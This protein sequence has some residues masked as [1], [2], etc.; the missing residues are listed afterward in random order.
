MGTYLDDDLSEIFTEFT[1]RKTPLY[2]SIILSLIGGFLLSTNFSLILFNLGI[3]IFSSILIIMQIYRFIENKKIIFKQLI[4]GLI[5]LMFLYIPL[6]LPNQLS[7][8]IDNIDAG[9]GKGFLLSLFLVLIGL[10]GVYINLSNLDKQ[11]KKAKQASAYLYLSFAILTVL[12]V[13]FLIIGFIVYNGAGA[14]TWEFIT[15]DIQNMGASGG[16]FP[17]IIGT[18]L[19]GLG[20][21]LISVPLGVGTAIFL[22]EYA[23][24]QSKL[25]RVI[26]TSIN[27]LNAT[28]SIVHGLFGLALFVPLFGV[29]LLTGSLVLGFLTLPI[30]IRSTEEALESVPKDIRDASF[31]MGATRWQ[32]IRNAV[33]PPALPGIVTGAVL[34]LGR[35]FGETAPI[36]FTAVIFSGGGIPTSV[37]DSVNALSYHLLEL[38]RLIGYKDVTQKAWGTALLLL[39]IV[40]AMNFLGIRIRKKYRT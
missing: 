26:R 25:V 1:L 32:T 14:I 8:P 12:F 9:I 40:L 13:L 30:I 6:I 31:A 15:Q 11:N 20:T 34:G 24:S 2:F 36:M 22:K 3:L 29:S 16:V 27:V 35:A 19:L 21:A 17:A 23:G 7:I 38:T 39:L 5:I 33:L 37:F 4:F 10:F 18:L 28:P